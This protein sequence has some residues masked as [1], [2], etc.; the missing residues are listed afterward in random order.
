V[1]C[2]T[3]LPTVAAR[4]RDHLKVRKDVADGR[5]AVA[6]SVLA[7]EERV[8]EIARLLGGDRAGSADGGSSRKAYARQ[9]LGAGRRAAGSA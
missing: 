2:I 6:V 9:L 7:G 5:T 1:I 3:H 4:G 8:A